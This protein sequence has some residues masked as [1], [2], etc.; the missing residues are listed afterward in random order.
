MKLLIII[1]VLLAFVFHRAAKK[2]RGRGSWAADRT[3]DAAKWSLIGAS[4][5]ILFL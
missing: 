4:I 2:T 1:P 3:L 5:V